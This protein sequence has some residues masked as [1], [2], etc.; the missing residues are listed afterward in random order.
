MSSRQPPWTWGETASDANPAEQ[1]VY[2]MGNGDLV[3]YV[4]PG[5][6]HAQ[7]MDAGREPPMPQGRSESAEADSNSRQYASYG[8]SNQPSQHNKVNK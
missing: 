8:G 1:G 7:L 6:L 4:P 3:H 5:S 2:T